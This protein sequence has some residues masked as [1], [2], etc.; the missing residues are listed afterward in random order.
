MPQNHNTFL[1]ALVSVV[2]SFMISVVANLDGRYKRTLLELELPRLLAPDL[3]LTH[4]PKKEIYLF[5][6]YLFIS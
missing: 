5:K 6:F 1:I 2:V 4:I 3:P